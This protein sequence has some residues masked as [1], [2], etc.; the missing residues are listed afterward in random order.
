MV[1]ID[2][3]EVNSDK[4]FLHAVKIPAVAA[5]VKTLDELKALVIDGQTVEALVIEE[6]GKTGISTA[7]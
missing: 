3:L 6:G 2:T 7:A 5:E 1:E 4:T